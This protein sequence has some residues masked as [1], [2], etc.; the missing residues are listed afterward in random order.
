MFLNYGVPNLIVNFHIMNIARKKIIILLFLLL[1][2]AVSPNTFVVAQTGIAQF[3]TL[4]VKFLIPSVLLIFITIG[5][6]ALLQ[7]KEVAHQALNGIFAGIIATIGLEIV[8]EAGFRLGTMPGDLPKLMGVLLLN[9]FALGPDFWSNLAGWSY[10]FWNGATFG[11]IFSLLIGKGKIWTGILYG[12]LIGIGFMVSP[13]TR[14][15]GVGLLGLDFKSGYEF[16][17]TV[18]IAHIAFGAILGWILSKMNMNKPDIISRIK[19]A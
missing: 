2:A 10:H 7:Y 4:A 13:V 3:S 12:V 8:R 1:F 5:I 11:L 18:M 19:D 16:A 14:S 9:R 17:T 15:L 6:A